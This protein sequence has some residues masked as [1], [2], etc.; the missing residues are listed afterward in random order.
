M[1]FLLGN[2]AWLLWLFYPFVIFVC[3][4]RKNFGRYIA[5]HAMKFLFCVVVV[6]GIFSYYWFVVN[7][8]FMLAY[9]KLKTEEMHYTSGVV[10]HVGTRNGTVVVLG[11]AE[12]FYC[13]SMASGACLSA[14]RGRAELKPNHEFMSGV[15]VRIGWKKY[16]SQKLIYSIEAGHEYYLTE[17]DSDSRFAKQYQAAERYVWMVLIVSVL[18]FIFLLII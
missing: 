8:N 16:Y 9:E 4:R 6:V 7:F 12:K 18:C 15:Q 11:N 17:R 5:S 13:D 10:W 1:D 2:S 3:Y 14:M